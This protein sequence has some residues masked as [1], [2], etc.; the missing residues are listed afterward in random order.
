MFFL[1]EAF[2][3]GDNSA[4]NMAPILAG[5]LK[6]AIARP[7]Y[8]IVNEISEDWILP[9][10]FNKRIDADTAPF[11]WKEMASGNLSLLKNQ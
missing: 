5:D 6:E 9:R 10:F 1:V 3:V 8:S 7:K 11:I 4:V 2:K